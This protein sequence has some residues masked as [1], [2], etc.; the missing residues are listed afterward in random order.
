MALGRDK[1]VSRIF[2]TKQP[3]C[4]SMYKPDSFLTENYPSLECALEVD[5]CEVQTTTLD[6]WSKEEGLEYI[7][8]IKLDT[9][10]SEL[11]ILRGGA[12]ILKT[13]RALEIEVEFNPI[14]SGQHLFSDVDI[15]M[16]ENGFALWKLTNMVH[17]YDQNNDLP[18]V[19]KDTIYYGDYCTQEFTKHSGQ[20]YWADAHYVRS[21]MLRGVYENPSLIA[22]DIELMSMIG[23]SDVSDLLGRH[24]DR[25]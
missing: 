17:Y 24:G 6:I 25:K 15:F 8:Y 20:L 19:G 4:S 22:R 2:L 14:Y 5:T 7:D 1:G 23:L 9:Q 11:D 18:P 13:V 3:A 16:R 12:D 21:D 10:G